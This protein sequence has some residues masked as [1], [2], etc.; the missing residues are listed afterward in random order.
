M[1]RALVTTFV[2]LVAVSGCG[3]SDKPGRPLNLDQARAVVQKFATAG[4]ASACKYL[5]PKALKDVYGNFTEPYEE[6]RAN[7][8]KAS[9]KFKG[10]PV[11][12]VKTTYLADT[13]VAKVVAHDA[14]EKFSYSVNLK[15]KPHRPWRI[16]SINQ[17]RLR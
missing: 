5:G 9:R 10:E 6:A 8:E 15:R 14:A 12:I 4:D 1:L 7:C 2:L 17:A 11:R 3:G 16:Y 13:G